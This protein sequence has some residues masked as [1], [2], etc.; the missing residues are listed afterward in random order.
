MKKFI[1]LLVLAFVAFTMPA[2][3]ARNGNIFTTSSSST[4]TSKS[5]AT[6]TPYKWADSKGQEYPIFLSKNGRAFVKRV[7][8]NTGKEYKHYLGEEISR[9]ICKE[10]GVE[11]KEK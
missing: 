5:E 10:M 2:Q 8:A 3:V 6:A 7:S 4:S 1:I 11:Y 9:T